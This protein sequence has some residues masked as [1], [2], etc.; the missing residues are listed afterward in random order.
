M[1]DNKERVLAIAMARGGDPAGQNRDGR[2]PMLGND[3]GKGET[4]E[5]LA[6]YV[7]IKTVSLV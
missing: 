7:D 1:A 2:F 6:K 3:K 5:Y 4:I